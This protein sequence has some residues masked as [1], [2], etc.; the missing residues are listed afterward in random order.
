MDSSESSEHGGATSEDT[1]GGPP[2]TAG[3]VL[4]ALRRDDLKFTMRDAKELFKLASR[5]LKL[6]AQRRKFGK[7]VEHNRHTS[8]ALCQ[9]A[10]GALVALFAPGPDP[11]ACPGTPR[12]KTEVEAR[13]TDSAH[14][15][16]HTSGAGGAASA[17]DAGAVCPMPATEDDDMHVLSGVCAMFSDG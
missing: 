16:S 14:G 3:D 13:S 15:W 8:D 7:L 9:L 6:V 17:V 4:E 12:K 10:Y 11:A 5:K 2:A 1:Y